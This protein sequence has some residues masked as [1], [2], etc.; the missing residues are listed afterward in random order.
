MSKNST[1]ASGDGLTDEV[2][3]KAADGSTS[4]V[5]NGAKPSNAMQ[6]RSLIRKLLSNRRS[7]RAV[8]ACGAIAGLA[9]LLVGYFILTGESV[10]PA[11]PEPTAAERFDEQFASLQ[12][13]DEAVV[14]M[15]A[16]EIDD[17]MLQKLASMDRLNTIQ[18][19]VSS[20][21][22]G[23]IALLAKM[24][25]LEQLHIRNAVINDEMLAALAESP[26]IWLLN[27][28][29]AEISPA[30]IKHLEKM[31][32][33]RQ[34]RLGIKDGD[35]GHGRA[36]AELSSLRSVHLIRVA[37]TDEGLQSLAKMPRLESLYLD[38]SVITDSGWQWLFE[39]NPQLHVHVNQQ[40][41]DRDPQKH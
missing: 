33:L 27:F 12:K 23:T 16:F 41:H 10:P 3:E 15:D 7:R 1:T 24:P 28:P 18:V 34:L 20:V 37:I 19:D 13:S 8:I 25:K 38:D 35:N 21:S 29:S 39:K 11:A 2:A 5:S 30:G 6:L 40:H 14:R 22:V 32:S 4:G 36:I 31:P 26:T 9:I 17:A